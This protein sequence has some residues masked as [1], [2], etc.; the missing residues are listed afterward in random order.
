[1]NEESVTEKE[2]L[3]TWTRGIFEAFV[4]QF[5]EVKGVRDIIG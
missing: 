2:R 4:Q 3:P 1:M 5:R